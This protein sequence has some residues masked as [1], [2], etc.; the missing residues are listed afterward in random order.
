MNTEAKKLLLLGAMGMHV[1]LLKRARERGIYTITCD[2]FPDAIGHSY[3]DE[4]H[5]DSTTDKEAVLQLAQKCQV[6]AVMTFNS[7]PAALT[8]AFVA[9]K[10]GLPSSGF[11]AVEVMSEKDKFRQFLSQHG[12]NTPKFGQFSDYQS[13]VKM[14]DQFTFP[15]MIKPVDSSGS[16]GISKVQC[17]DELPALFERAL[18]NSRCKRVIVEEFITG[19]GAQLHGDAFVK[20]G[21]IE[22]IYLG[23]HHFDREV[24][25]LVPISTTFPSCHSEAEQELVRAEVQAFISKVGFKQGG[26]NVEARI[27]ADNKVYL[28]EVGPRNGGNFTPIVIQYAS[29]F[30]FVDACLD[31]YLGIDS[32][33][34][35]ACKKGYF[36]YMIPHSKEAGTLERID[37]SPE[38]QGKILERHD[39]VQAGGPVNSFVG[40]NAAVGV[41]LVR[42]N[43]AEEMEQYVNN[44]NHHCRVIL[45]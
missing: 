21:Q 30:N 26:I 31:A 38:L 20:D 9:D 45:K 43:S 39:Y 40:A 13:L 3:A 28:I 8:A 42:F 7:D 15:V 1:P 35:Q 32:E 12:F 22:F 34:Q 11:Q 24:N 18:D 33:P 10:L 16:K 4:A 14:V 5:V 29:G 44:C 2:Y 6:D 37:I 23:D 27:T 19:Q 17:A 25:N 41:L 36:A